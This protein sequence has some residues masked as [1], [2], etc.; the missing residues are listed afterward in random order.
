MVVDCPIIHCIPDKDLLIKKINFS[1]PNERNRLFCR[2]N[3]KKF[4]SLLK[5][6]L[7]LEGTNKLSDDG[8]SSVESHSLERHN[9]VYGKDKLLF[10]NSKIFP[11][12]KN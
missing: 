3:R 11:L 4:N 12:K 9:F 6:N 7:V 5:N 2:F 10:E 8:E 1:I